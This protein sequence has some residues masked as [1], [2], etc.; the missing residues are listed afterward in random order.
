MTAMTTANR[1]SGVAPLLVFFDAVDVVAS[2]SGVPQS[3][4]ESPWL[5]S[6]G[7][8]QPSDYEGILYEWNFGDS[9]SGTW[10]PTGLSRNTATGYTAAHV[11]ETAGTYTV[12]LTVTDTGGT[13]YSYSQSIT[14]SAISGTTYYVAS[15]GSDANNGTSTNTPFLT[16]EHGLTMAAAN[17]SILL[18]RGDTF[19]EGPLVASG[20]GPLIIG[21]YGAGNRPIINSSASG[22]PGTPE[23]PVRLTGTDW[24]VMDVEIQGT[25]WCALQAEGSPGLYLRCF[26]NSNGIV[27][28]IGGSTGNQSTPLDGV[29]FV[30]CEV[31]SSNLYGG[32]LE[33][34]RGVV[35]GNNIH[36][37]SG[38]HVLRV[39]Q[40][41][42]GVISNNRLWWTDAAR[43]SL[44]LHSR[45]V[46]DGFL[47][48][49]QFVV[50]SDNIVYGNQ[51]PVHF[52]PQDTGADEIVS[53]V[54][55]E[56]NKHFNSSVTIAHVVIWADDVICR[57]NVMDMS[58]GSTSTYGF[59]ATHGG[60]EPNHFNIRVYNNTI[61]RSDACTEL[62]ALQTNTSAT[63]VEYKNNIL[64]APSGSLTAVEG[65]PGAGF[66]QS[67]NVTTSTN[68][69]FVN[70]A[71]SDF[72]LTATTQATIVNAGATLSEVR[73]DFLRLLRPA[74]AAYDVGAYEY[75]ATGGTTPATII[76]IVRGTVF[77]SDTLAAAIG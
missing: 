21:A 22:D 13:V 46:D 9:N 62:I 67:N 44:K 5:W 20:T 57:N 31:D 27:V 12:S 10:T 49:T 43:H 2:G 33:A 36:D 14:V 6:S 19:N 34:R 35:M 16:V 59:L 58:G 4:P 26:V 25:G 17:R 75:G 7:V 28:G 55:Y 24:R 41:H 47:G 71:G 37:I 61:A 68:P 56:R 63:N 18:R 40:M 38:S 15:N 53:H 64:Y 48:W 11:F 50:I 52:S 54:V 42:H 23:F 70:L 69:N 66:S 3:S 45:A 73:Q 51:E 77:A 65:T 1:T 30:E 32:Y 72:R 29:G 39:P 76:D 8:Y 74:G 60:A